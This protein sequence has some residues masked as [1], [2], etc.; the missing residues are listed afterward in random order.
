M[1]KRWNVLVDLINEHDLQIGVEVGVKSGL[2]M[3][4]ILNRCFNFTFYGVDPWCGTDGYEHWSRVQVA[5]HEKEARDVE[6]QFR[7]RC[8]LIKDFSASA[9]KQFS[10]KSI[11]LVF[12]D[13]EHTYEA[14]TTDIRCWLPKLRKGGIIAGHDY[15]NLTAWRRKGYD[16]S[17]VD[18][19]VDEAFGGR[20]NVAEDHVWWVK[21]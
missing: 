6:T 13:G 3:R 20:V 8:R 4:R 18:T 21:V 19:A 17:G 15:K 16:F 11:D 2:N 10:N 5:G 14:V 12:I 9:S 1:K 7:N